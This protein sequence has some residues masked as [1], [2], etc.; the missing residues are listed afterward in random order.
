MISDPQ[1]LY[2]QGW[3]RSLILFLDRQIARLARHWLAVFNV[4][5]AIYTLLPVLAPLLMAW[6]APQAGRI[7]YLLYAPACHQ[8]PER[9]LFFFGPQLTYTVDELWALGE[10]PQTDLLSRKQF[11]GSPL[12]GYKT[13]FCQRDLALYGGLLI[14]GLAFGLVRRR[15]KPMSLLAFGLCLL[16]LVLDGGTQLIGLRESNVWL[17]LFTGGLGGLGTIW[18]LYPHVQ[19][20]FDEMRYQADQRLNPPL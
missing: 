13:A 1:T 19:V 3:R 8:L 12:V 5:A 15:L 2:T 18:M 16:P 4:C 17:R 14:G 6:S 20:A 9:S 7:I 11:I 10:L